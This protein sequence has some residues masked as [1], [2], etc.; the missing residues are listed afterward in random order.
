MISCQTK[1]GFCLLPSRVLAYIQIGTFVLVVTV[2]SWFFSTF[3]FTSRL[4]VIKPEQDCII[5]LQQKVVQHFANRGSR[6]DEGD[7]I[8]NANGHSEEQLTKPGEL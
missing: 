1:T 3:F 4:K 6:H 5:E 8:V 2:H 7:T